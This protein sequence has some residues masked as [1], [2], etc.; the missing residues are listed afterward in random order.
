M[1]QCRTGIGD[2]FSTDDRHGWRDLSEE[3]FDEARYDF[4]PA[5]GPKRAKHCRVVIADG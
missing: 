5:H 1:P 2:F 4:I 3:D